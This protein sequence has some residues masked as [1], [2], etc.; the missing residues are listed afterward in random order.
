MIKKTNNKN[1]F[2]GIKYQ[3]I[4]VVMIKLR[5]YILN[6]EYWLGRERYS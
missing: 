4:R 6:G 2:V 3:K 1:V 5:Y